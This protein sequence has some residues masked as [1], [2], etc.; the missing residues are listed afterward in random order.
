MK[1]NLDKLRVKTAFEQACEDGIS[2]R[3][4]AIRNLY[5][6]KRSDEADGFFK[7]EEDEDE[8]GQR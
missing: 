1:T 5:R 6:I 4:E 2:W 7:P 3:M 8:R